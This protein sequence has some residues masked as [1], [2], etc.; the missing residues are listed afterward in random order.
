MP[1]GVDDAA[2]AV[3]IFKGITSI[4]GGGGNDGVDP[5]IIDIQKR[6]GEASLKQME[7]DQQTM[8]PFRSSLA[9]KLAERTGQEL[10]ISDITGGQTIKSALQNTVAP[11]QAI[12]PASFLGGRAERS[13]EN[14]QIPPQIAGKPALG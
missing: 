12:D 8:N 3:A 9:V 1:F 2:A 13:P 6:I 5:G 4:F 7:N 14:Q 11:T 10:P